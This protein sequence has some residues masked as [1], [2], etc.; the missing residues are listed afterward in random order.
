MVGGGTG[1][2]NP[3]RTS[4]K[5]PQEEAQPG[6]SEEPQGRRFAG[7]LPPLLRTAFPQRGPR[8]AEIHHQY[9]RCRDR[10]GR[11]GGV[12]E[13]KRKPPAH[14]MGKR[15]ARPARFLGHS[16]TVWTKSARHPAALPRPK[17]H[18][19][20]PPLRQP[21]WTLENKVHAGRKVS[22]A[23]RIILSW[24]NQFLCFFCTLFGCTK[25]THTHTALDSFQGPPHS[26]SAG[27]G[28]AFANSRAGQDVSSLGPPSGTPMAKLASAGWPVPA[29]PAWTAPGLGPQAG[30]RGRRGQGV[31][32]SGRDH[33]A[34]PGPQ[35]CRTSLNFSPPCASVSSTV[36]WCGDLRKVPSTQQVLEHALSPSPPLSSEQIQQHFWRSP[37]LPGPGCGQ[38]GLHEARSSGPGSSRTAQVSGSL[39]RGEDSLRTGRLQPTS[40]G[41]SMEARRQKVSWEV[42]ENRFLGPTHRA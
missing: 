33:S 15:R 22:E 27:L 23:H 39:G 29:W 1:C 5:I 13:Q 16:A 2:R 31:Q 30:G 8:T 42:C 21:P 19:P 32:G 35:L 6:E 24:D 14:S 34:G 37:R 41:H 40:R 3:T 36:K 10:S 38:D 28:D 17:K 20:A 4:T 7:S 9:S 11:G 12:P 25:V 26:C 18:T